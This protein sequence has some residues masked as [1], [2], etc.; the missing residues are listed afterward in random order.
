MGLDRVVGCVAC[1][2]DALLVES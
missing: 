1:G 2:H